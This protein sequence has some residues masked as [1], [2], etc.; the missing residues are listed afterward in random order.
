MC[1]PNQ[2]KLKK[3]QSND[4]T[5]Y[6]CFD[7][8]D[9]KCQVL[10]TQHSSVNGFD[11]KT[12][13]AWLGGHTEETFLSLQVIHSLVTFLSPQVKIKHPKTTP[14]SL[15]PCGEEISEA[16]HQIAFDFSLEFI[17][18]TVEQVTHFSF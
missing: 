6:I 18:V 14:R 7:L 10:K 17:S 16:Q 15:H 5:T 11:R 3:P 4:S 2:L 13:C 12:H 8:C 1:P 9:I